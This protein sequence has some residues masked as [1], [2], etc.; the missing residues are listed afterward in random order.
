M[1]A[2]VKLASP[3]N[4][5]DPVRCADCGPA[6]ITCLIHLPPPA[7]PLS[8][9]GPRSYT[10][11]LLTAAIR[12]PARPYHAGTI[13]VAPFYRYRAAAPLLDTS[14]VATGSGGLRIS[15]MRQG[16]DIRGLLA[17]GPDRGGCRGRPLTRHVL[18]RV[19]VRVTKL[20]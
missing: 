8:D 20:G 7:G 19:V 16:A 11:G 6:P 2:Q 15:G 17:G 10:Y 18:L 9:P 12:I 4:P 1:P 5:V 3:V 13:R 14:R